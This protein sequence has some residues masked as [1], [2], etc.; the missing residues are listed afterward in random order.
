MM[1][2]LRCSAACALLLATVGASPAEATTLRE[3]TFVERVAASELV[4]RGTVQ[5][6]W[7]EYGED[8]Q[9]WTRAQLE[10]ERVYKGDVDSEFL[11][12]DQ[13]GGTYAGNLQLVS[14]GA[15]FSPG[16]SV[17]MM[18]D[19]RPNG[20]LMPLGM[21]TGKWTIRIDPYTQGEI[22]QRFSPSMAEDYDHRFI[23]LPKAEERQTLGDLEDHILSVVES[24]GASPASRPSEVRR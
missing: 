23:P 11:V 8:G 3:M 24:A 2:L 1:N 9:V 22:V 13:V 10:V 17:V 16:E 19:Q 12:I 7:T 20:R 15:R 14:G 4:V 6:V 21:S 5:E 18:L